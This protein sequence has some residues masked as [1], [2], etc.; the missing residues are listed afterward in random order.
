MAASRA[1]LDPGSFSGRQS[2]AT[3]QPPYRKRRGR[4]PRRRGRQRCARSLSHE[5]G[6]LPSGS[7]QP[8]RPD[9]WAGGVATAPLG[10]AGANPIQ[11]GGVRPGAPVRN[12][13]LAAS[14]NNR[15]IWLSAPGRP[16]GTRSAAV[17]F[18]ELVAV[19][20]TGTPPTSPASPGNLA[21]VVLALKR[22]VAP[23]AAR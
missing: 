23:D 21:D 15:V 13:D 8:F 7:T 10:H 14:L 1:Q 9:G 18:R 12:T 4:A 6:R 22:T 5:P 3:M 19:S 11:L 17:L 16:A 2:S 20:R